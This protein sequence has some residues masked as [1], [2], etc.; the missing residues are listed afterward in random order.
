M[1]ADPYIKAIPDEATG[2]IQ[3][4][5]DK[6]GCDLF[7]RL[8]ARAEPVRGDDLRNFTRFKERASGAFLAASVVMGW[9]KR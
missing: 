1:S 5:M 3:F 2:R 8:I 9:D 6:A 4:V 7:R